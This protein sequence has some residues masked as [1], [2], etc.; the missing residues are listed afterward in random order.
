MIK[1]S[2]IIIAKDE[3]NNI[4]RC[5]SSLDNI[6]DDAV[7]II[8]SRT[9]DK[10]FEISKTFSF[11][12]SEVIEW[13]GYSKTK[14]YALSKTKY[15]WVLW[16]DADEE[17]TPQLQNELKEFKI[18]E[19][20]YDCY[21]VARRAYF[22]NKWIKHSGWYPNR[23]K[24]LFNKSK[25]FFDDKDVHEGLI[26]NGK[27]GHLKH[28][29]NHYTDPNIFHYLEK[30]NNYTSLAAEEL[31]NKNKKTSLNDIFL[32]P[33]FIFVKMFILRLGFLDGFHGFLLA[34]F[35][36]F[37]VFTKYVKLWEFYKK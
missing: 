5:L 4:L 29:L 35:S 8:D 13:K 18:N 28:D 22:L 26:V 37:Y 19:P 36:S 1:L 24:R 16:I 11:V 33:L 2:A 7:V 21:D 30:L 12:N 23:I 17:L 32:R 10:T 9:K 31:Y 27:I 15:D 6:I 20:E 34:S 3:E 14:I 25:I